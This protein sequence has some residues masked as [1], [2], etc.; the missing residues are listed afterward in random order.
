MLRQARSKSKQ[1]NPQFVRFER[2]QDEKNMKWGERAAVEMAAAGPDKW[3]Y[4]ALLGGSDT[5]SFRLRVAQSHLRPDLLPSYWSEVIL[6]HLQGAGL[7]GA[8]AIHVPLAQP[9]GFEFAPRVNGVVERPLS[10][11]DDTNLYPNIALVALPVPQTEILDRVEQFKRSR[12]TLDA[13]EHVLRWVAFG[14]GVARTPNPLHENFG[15]PSACMLETVCAAASID[16][17]PG[18]ESRASCPEAIWGAARFWH[19]FYRQSR[20][21]SPVGRYWHPHTFPVVEPQ[22]PGSKK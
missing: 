10:D 19:E 13:L 7:A 20:G 21:S 22:E 11:F 8:R 1:D 6:I 15:L 3:T 16:L 18:L 9:G 5:M 17:T 14:W 2:K 4:L 12:S